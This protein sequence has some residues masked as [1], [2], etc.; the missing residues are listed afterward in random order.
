MTNGEEFKIY[1]IFSVIL[2]IFTQA[3]EIDLFYGSNLFNC[4]M[5]IF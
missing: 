2:L 4:F 3:L 5:V 1:S